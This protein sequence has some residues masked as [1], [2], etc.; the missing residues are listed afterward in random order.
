MQ[1]LHLL[2]LGVIPHSMTRYIYF[3]IVKYTMNLRD[4]DSVQAKIGVTLLRVRGPMNEETPAHAHPHY[5]N[6]T[7]PATCTPVLIGLVVHW[8]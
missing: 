4:V 7:T 3:A 6:N 2:S 5:E 8:F 1:A